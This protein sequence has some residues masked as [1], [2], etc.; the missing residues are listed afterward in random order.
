MLLSSCL[1]C[2]ASAALVEGSD[3]ANV[4]LM[5]VSDA[6]VHDAQYR[7]LVANEQSHQSFRQFYPL[8]VSIN[9]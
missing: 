1:L 9:N 3:P 7:M 5:K 6:S 4:I 2:F 8:P